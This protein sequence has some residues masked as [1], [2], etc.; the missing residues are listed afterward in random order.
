MV[1][2]PLTCRSESFVAG[3]ATL[4]VLAGAVGR[5]AG[6]GAALLADFVAGV[7]PTGDGLAEAPLGFA[8]SAEIVLKT[9]RRTFPLASVFRSDRPW[10]KPSRFANASTV[11]PPRRSCSTRFSNSLAWLLETH[12]SWSDPAGLLAL[13]TVFAGALDFAATLGL[14]AAV[15]GGAVDAVPLDDEESPED[16]PAIARI[17]LRRSREVVR[18]GLRRILRSGEA[19]AKPSSCAILDVP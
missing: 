17:R 4:A 3:V 14:D 2:P 1:T 12:A 19:S 6:A 15:F 10:W 18:L 16:L 9:R 5:D 8:E 7:G 11:H 13:A